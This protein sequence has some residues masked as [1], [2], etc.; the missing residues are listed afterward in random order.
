MAKNSLI[1]GEKEKY[2]DDSP[3]SMPG[4]GGKKTKPK[5][6]KFAPSI[7]LTASQVAAFGLEDATQGQTGCAMIHYVVKGVDAGGS[8]YGDE[9]PDTSKSKKKVSISITHVDP[10]CETA[11]REGKDEDAEDEES[12][13]DEAPTGADSEDEEAEDEDTKP[14][15]PDKETMSP[16]DA[17][18][19]GE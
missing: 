15:A 6:R 14:K 3:M 4:E 18:G 16:A 11:G 19:D 5:Q 9:L 1:I 7:Q 17:L 13:D 12:P 8:S 10:D 2:G